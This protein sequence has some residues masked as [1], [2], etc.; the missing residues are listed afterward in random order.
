MHLV[1]PLLTIAVK[2]AKEAPPPPPPFAPPVLFVMWGL[3]F[4]PFSAVLGFR[5]TKQMPVVGAGASASLLR[6]V[7]AFFSL[8]TVLNHVYHLG[9]MLGL[10]LEF[11]DSLFLAG[12]AFGVLPS[13]FCSCRCF[14][15][16]LPRKR[17]LLLTILNIFIITVWPNLTKAGFGLPAEQPIAVLGAPEYNK[18]QGWRAPAQH[19]ATEIGI[20]LVTLFTYMQM[21]PVIGNKAHMA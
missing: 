16:A 17:A 4:H 2:A 8:C 20:T 3:F 14:F 19:F 1:A 11:Q 10:S 7:F 18:V 13:L 12:L 15:L 21:A 5:M 9:A 6:V